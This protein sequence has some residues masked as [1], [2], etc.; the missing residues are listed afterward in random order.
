MWSFW[1]ENWG[2]AFYWVMFS[3]SLIGYIMSLIYNWTL[4][5]LIINAKIS[6]TFHE[7]SIIKK[8]CEF[9]LGINRVWVTESYFTFSSFKSGPLRMYHRIIFNLYCTLLVGAEILCVSDHLLIF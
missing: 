6:T 4:L 5:Y 7:D 2:A 9:S 8:E 3:C 1:N